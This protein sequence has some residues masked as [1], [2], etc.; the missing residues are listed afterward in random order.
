MSFPALDL[1]FAW[2]DPDAAIADAKAHIDQY[3][4]RYTTAR[5]APSAEL[6]T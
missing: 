3:R 4:Q 5:P 1:G 2:S 6:R